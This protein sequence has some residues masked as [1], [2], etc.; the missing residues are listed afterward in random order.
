[1]KI[2]CEISSPT[3]INIG[4]HI[5][6]VVLLIDRVIVDTCLTST[7]CVWTRWAIQYIG[8]VFSFNDLVIRL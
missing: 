3:K 4:R 1:M 8:Y 5:G 7:A 2:N 6:G